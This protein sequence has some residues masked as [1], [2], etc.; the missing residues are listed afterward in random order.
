M[1]R[2][3]PP[4]FG[5]NPEEQQLFLFFMRLSLSVNFFAMSGNPLVDW[6]I[7]GLRHIWF[8]PPQILSTNYVM[9]RSFSSWKSQLQLKQ[10]HKV[11]YCWGLFINYVLIFGGFHFRSPMYWEYIVYS[12]YM[13]G[14]KWKPWISA[15]NDDVINEQPLRQ[16]DTGRPA[17]KICRWCSKAFLKTICTKHIIFDILMF[18]DQA[19]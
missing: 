10:N 5:Q 4:S 18:S 11:I 15:Q 17:C 2:A 13:V 9:R 19:W 12:Q 1:S 6:G 7:R 8:H 16:C 3:P 14:L